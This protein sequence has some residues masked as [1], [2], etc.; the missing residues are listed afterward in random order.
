MADGAGVAAEDGDVVGT[1]VGCGTLVL[2]AGLG[3]ICAVGLGVAA[4]RDAE[5]AALGEAVGCAFAGET[6]AAGGGLTSR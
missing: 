2:G 5:G 1:P 6:V 3:V 4:D